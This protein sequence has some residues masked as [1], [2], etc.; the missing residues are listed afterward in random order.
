MAELGNFNLFI[1]VVMTITGFAG[2]YVAK[3]QARSKIVW[4]ILCLIPLFLIILLFKQPVRE[5]EG[6]I[7]QCPSCKGFISWNSAFCK[8]CSFELTIKN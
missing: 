1:I 3:Q 6:K 8:H 7:K 2:M 4:F 5:I